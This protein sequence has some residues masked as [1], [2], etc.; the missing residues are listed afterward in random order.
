M[1]DLGSASR[2]SSMSMSNYGGP[3]QMEEVRK[4][5]DQQWM[6]EEQ[7]KMKFLA[8]VKKEVVGMGPPA[9]L[10]KLTHRND[11]RGMY[12]NDYSVGPGNPGGR[13]DQLALRDAPGGPIPMPGRNDAMVPRHENRS[14]LPRNLS[15]SSASSSG[16]ARS[17][18]HRA[19]RRRDRG[20]GLERVEER[21]RSSRGSMSESEG[22]ESVSEA[23]S[24]AGIRHTDFSH[25]IADLE[26]KL[27]NAQTRVDDAT[28][29]CQ[30]EEERA[31]R[32]E[33]ELKKNK[34][35][36]GGSDLE[37]QLMENLVQLRQQCMEMQKTRQT[38]EMQVQAIQDQLNEEK[39]LR[40][41]AEKALLDAAKQRTELNQRIDSLKTRAQSL[42]AEV[43]ERSQQMTGLQTGIQ[44][45]EY[46]RDETL[47][48]LERAVKQKEQ[49]K[50][51]RRR[52]V[53]EAQNE[54]ER[55]REKQLADQTEVRRLLA[56]IDMLLAKVGRDESGSNI[57]TVREL[58]NV[59]D[60]MRSLV[61]VRE[62][63]GGGQAAPSGG[64][65]KSDEKPAKKA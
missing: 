49:L 59:R 47:E 4:R 34:E 6:S 36:L 5:G 40:Q 33:L 64:A 60:G 62:N 53:E 35:R 23:G 54:V 63:Q 65:G 30:E 16:S 12:G 39:R 26:A 11:D 21:S 9:A 19:R 46:E 51:G 55:L 3:D 1:S 58:V 41:E 15:H 29:R 37:M 13:M 2:A 50:R 27:K 43:S 20:G 42:E 22:S 38:E 17:D 10:P 48:L 61:K 7:E 31:Q 25:N 28:E 24:E 44:R 14:V 52:E 8:N 56:R 18:R 57:E 32:A 45:V